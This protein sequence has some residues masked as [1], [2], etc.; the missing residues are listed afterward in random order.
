MS[1]SH[2][3]LTIGALHLAVAEVLPGHKVWLLSLSLSFFARKDVADRFDKPPSYYRSKPFST[4][5][6]GAKESV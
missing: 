5:S 1:L 6:D 3:Y 2:E 4:K